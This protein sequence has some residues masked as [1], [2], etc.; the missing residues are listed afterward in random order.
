M[1]EASSNG[2]VRGRLALDDVMAAE[3]IAL[4]LGQS[5]RD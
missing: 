3:R 2:G 1:G 5:R 4:R